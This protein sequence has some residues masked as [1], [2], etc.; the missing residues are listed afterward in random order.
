MLLMAASQGEADVLIWTKTV[1]ALEKSHGQKQQSRWN[2]FVKCRS[3][4]QSEGVSRRSDRPC[5]CLLSS[6]MSLSP[7]NKKH[8]SPY[9]PGKPRRLL[10][11][12]FGIFHLEVSEPLWEKES[13]LP[14]SSFRVPASFIHLVCVKHLIPTHCYTR[15]FTKSVHSTNKLINFK[16]DISTTARK[17]SIYT[18]KTSSI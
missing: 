14:W 18:W 16:T 3:A 2:C 13:V 4:A 10:V 9:L 1:K 15:V 11:P 12:Y 7:K 6:T 8:L 5:G 17:K